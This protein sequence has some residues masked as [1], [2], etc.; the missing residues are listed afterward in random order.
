[1]S[2]VDGG[3]APNGNTGQTAP[4]AG[5]QPQGGQPQGGQQANGQPQGGQQANGQPQGGQ[6]Q[7]EKPTLA[8]GQQ[9]QPD[10]Q[11]HW[12]EALTDE[13]HKMLQSGSMI[14]QRW[15]RH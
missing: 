12:R 6:P 5:G 7:I 11:P 9:Q 3:Q 13:K 8:N 2:N 1:M 4:A 14:C 10:Q 15:F